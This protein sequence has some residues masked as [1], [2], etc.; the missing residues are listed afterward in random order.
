MENDSIWGVLAD[1]QAAM[2]QP[3]LNCTNPYFK[4][5]Y[6]DLGECMRVVRKATDGTGLFV[7][8]N[9]SGESVCTEV[10]YGDQCVSLAP[11]PFDPKGTPQDVGSAITYAKRYSIC[12]AFAL[13]ADED[14]DGNNAQDAAERPAS[15]A[16]V[17]EILMA[18]S[19]FAD[20]KGK[21]IE[22]VL[23]AVYNSKSI[24]ALGVT[25][26]DGITE[27]N[28][29]AVLSVIEGWIERSGNEQG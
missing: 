27:R 18:A 17:D 28:A 16:I 19:D 21:R 1:A 25:S 2:D 13:V 12:A 3:R 5:R 20:M 14:D 23:S 6:A 29:S 22:D 8:F 7:C 15:R 24:K 11:V 26:L 4:S 10:H 9:I